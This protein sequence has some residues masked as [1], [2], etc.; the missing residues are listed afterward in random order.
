MA[1]ISTQLAHTILCRGPSAAGLSKLLA[2][3][4][5]ED[6]SIFQPGFFRPG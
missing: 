4:L 6:S 1:G 5:K 2:H 3:S